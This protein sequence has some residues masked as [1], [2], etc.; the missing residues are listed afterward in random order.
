MLVEISNPHLLRLLQI[1]FP[2][3]PSMVHKIIHLTTSVDSTPSAAVHPMM[4][5]SL[6]PFRD[7]FR[8][9]AQRKIQK[10][11]RDSSLLKTSPNLIL[12]LAN[13]SSGLM[14]LARGLFDVGMHKEVASSEFEQKLAITIHNYTH[15]DSTIKFNHCFI[16]S[17]TTIYIA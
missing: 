5:D 16:H 8:S 4:A 6:T 13:H 9:I 7:L 15:R 1:Q 3:H 11:I 12:I 2:A 10:S 14:N 17:Q